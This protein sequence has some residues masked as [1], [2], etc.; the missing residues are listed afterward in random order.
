MTIEEIQNEVANKR[1]NSGVNWNDLHYY[2]Q[3]DLWP[4]VCKRYA[5]ECCKAS[6]KKAAESADYVIDYTK[7][8]T[9]TKIIKSSI[10][11]ESNITLL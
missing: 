6:L 1:Y 2:Y 7:F 11:E 5:T 4:E 8:G 10:T 9:N 3:A